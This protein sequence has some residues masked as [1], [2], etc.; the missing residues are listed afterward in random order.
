MPDDLRNSM[1]ESASKGKK[2]GDFS[3]SKSTIADLPST[4]VQSIH[5]ENDVPVEVDDSAFIWHEFVKVSPSGTKI[6]TKTKMKKNENKNFP[7]VKVNLPMKQSQLAPSNSAA[8]VSSGTK[9][10]T[11]V[12]TKERLSDNNVNRSKQN[13]KAIAKA[14]SASRLTSKE[15]RMPSRTKANSAT[16]LVETRPKNSKTKLNSKLRFKST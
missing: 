2:D 12:P 7:Q 14:E 9:L 13:I 8:K 4:A 1:E 6:S 11:K 15:H 10:V 3:C 16:K 5:I